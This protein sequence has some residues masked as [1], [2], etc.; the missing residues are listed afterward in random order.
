MPSPRLK[1]ELHLLDKLYPAISE[2][3]TVER[4]L[5]DPDAVKVLLAEHVRG[6]ANNLWALIHAADLEITLR[7]LSDGDGY[8]IFNGVSWTN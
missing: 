1:D 5:I 7:L 6:E 4:G 3:Q 8:K 2:K